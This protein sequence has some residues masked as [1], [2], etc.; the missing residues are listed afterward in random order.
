MGTLETLFE[1]LDQALPE[2]T[3]ALNTSVDKLINFCLVF[4]FRRGVRFTE[5]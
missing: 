2:S 5:V 4:L 1:L 3:I